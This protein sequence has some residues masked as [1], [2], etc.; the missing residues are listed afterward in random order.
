MG[1][2]EI[3]K[4]MDIDRDGI[5][6]K[7][8]LLPEHLI[9]DV[10]TEVEA[11]SEV[12]NK[13]GIRNAEKKFKTISKIAR[14]Q[15]L[16]E[17]AR[18]ILNDAPK[19]V[20]VIFFDKT[21]EKNWLVSWHQDKTVALSQKFELDGWGPWTIKENIHHVQPP[22]EV[23]NKMAT[24][25]IHLDS[26]NEENGCLR[27]VLGSH[28]LGILKQDQISE[29][30]NKEKVVPCVVNKGDTLI[31][32]PHIL[33]SSSKAIKPNHRRVIHIEFSSYKLPQNVRWA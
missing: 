7:K 3:K 33:H 4:N 27:I 11:T 30:V 10:I 2:I 32:R 23:L 22:L 5:E 31:M 9:H 6:I 12:I 8:G 18:V 24:F 14:C 16:I 15:E 21:P 29:I 26:A 13:H 25:R 1:V 19:V 17:E 28:K 20:R